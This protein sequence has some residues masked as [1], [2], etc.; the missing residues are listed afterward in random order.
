MQAACEIDPAMNDL[1]RKR[2]LSWPVFAFFLLVGCLLAL[3]IVAGLAEL[4]LGFTIL[5][6]ILIGLIVLNRKSIADAKRN[7]N[8]GGPFGKLPAGGDAPPEDF[9]HRLAHYVH[10]DEA[11][12]NEPGPPYESRMPFWSLVDFRSWHGPKPAWLIRQ[13]LERIRACVRG[14]MRR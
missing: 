1:P 2:R 4:V 12:L 3:S 14:P 13:V 8:K 11:Q 5:A 7:R 10:C 6:V 9:H